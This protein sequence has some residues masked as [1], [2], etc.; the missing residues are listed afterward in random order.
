MTVKGNVQQRN[1]LGT[2]TTWTHTP[3]GFG[4]YIFSAPI[5]L[6]C[7]WEK[8]A[9]TFRDSQGEEITSIAIIYVSADVSI[10]DYIYEGTTTVADPTTLVE[11]RRVRQFDKMS[12][13]RNIEI[14][15]RVFL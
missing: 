12:D 10:G 3:D 2:A 8:R 1:L 11:A 13:L 6:K 5:A 7:R 15:R 14:L 4:G 9:T